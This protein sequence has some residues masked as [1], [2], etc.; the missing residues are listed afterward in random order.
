MPILLFY[1]TLFFAE[2]IMK[3]LPW[4]E[5]ACTQ[6]RLQ[7]HGGFTIPFSSI[8][9]SEAPITSLPLVKNRNKS[10]CFQSYLITAYHFLTS[11]IRTGCLVYGCFHYWI[12]PSDGCHVS[13]WC[14]KNPDEEKKKK[15][16]RCMGG[17][18]KC[19]ASRMFLSKMEVWQPPGSQENRT[20]LVFLYRFVS[21]LGVLKYG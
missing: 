17:D 16:S 1:Q 7:Q 2:E 3:N 11:F 4:V 6:R 8:I 15:N 9:P 20:R 18:S 5:M 14:A 21:V 19:L 13:K 10:F 12:S